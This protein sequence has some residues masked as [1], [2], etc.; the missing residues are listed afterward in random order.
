MIPS[1]R[2]AWRNHAACRGCDPELFFPDR[3]GPSTAIAAQAKAICAAC[4]VR[5]ECLEEAIRDNEEYGVRGGM[6]PRERRRLRRERGMVPT[7]APVQ[8]PIRHGTVAGHLAHRRRGETPCDGC[9]QA[10]AAYRAER[11]EVKAGM[12]LAQGGAA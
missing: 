10:A 1:D 11:R 9:K 6:T 12:R 2:D 4:P 3:G 8:Q 5:T 7:W